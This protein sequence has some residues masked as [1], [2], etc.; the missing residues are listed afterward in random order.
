MSNDLGLIASIA[1]IGSNPTSEI[2]VLLE[3]ISSREFILSM[4]RRLQLGDDI[5]NPKLISQTQ[6]EKRRKPQMVLSFKQRLVAL[7]VFPNL[8]DRENTRQR[9]ETQ[10]IINNYKKG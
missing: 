1:G 3:K 9:I 8:L 2:D 6:K 10:N 4:N 5:F 7:R